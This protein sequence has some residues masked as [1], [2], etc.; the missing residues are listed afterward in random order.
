VARSI[1]V[2]N[3]CGVVSIQRRVSNNAV[4]QTAG[5]AE[6]EKNSRVPGKESAVEV[7]GV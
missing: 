5:R 2:K 4:E 1:N 7:L 3:R 6:R